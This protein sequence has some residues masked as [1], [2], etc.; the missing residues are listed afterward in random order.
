MDLGNALLGG[1][2][3]ALF[4][5]IMPRNF[6]QI[7]FTAKDVR[8]EVN[9][10]FTK[11]AIIQAAL[12]DAE[13]KQWTNIAVKM[14]IND[15]RDFAYDLE[16]MLDEH[17]TSILERILKGQ[18]KRNPISMTMQEVK[19]WWE[20]FNK[21]SS[22]RCMTQRLEELCERKTLL[23]LIENTSHGFQRPPSTSL[24]TELAICG[25]DEDKRKL[26]EMMSAETGKSNFRV[27]SI[28][29]MSGIGKTTLAKDVF[30]DITIQFDLKVWICVSNRFDVFRISKS[31]L[32][33]ISHSACDLNDLN[34][35]QMKL[36]SAVSGKRFLLVLD[37]VW[38]KHYDLWEIFRS[39]LLTGG[40]GSRIL[41]T[42][43]SMD[44]ALTMGDSSGLYNLKLLSDD[45]CWHVFQNH[46]FGGTKN[47]DFQVRDK[48]VQKCSGLPLAARTLG[49]LLRSKSRDDEWED[50]LNS[51]LWDLPEE[52]SILPVLKLNY[53]Y[54]P[55]YLKRCFA[56]CAILPKNYEFEEKEL[57]HL[58]IAEGL[59]LPLTNNR[60]LEEM[61]G[62]Y[63]RKL[64]SKSFF[65]PS[66]GDESKFVMHN[67]F[68]DL[69]QWVS[70]ETIF[71]REDELEV[72]KMYNTLQHVRHYSY[73]VLEYDGRNKFKVI[74]EVNHE[75][76][77]TFLPILTHNFD[78]YIS[79]EVI[80]DLLPKLKKLRVLSLRKY[81][82]TELPDSIGKLRYLRYLNLADTDIASLPESVMD[83]INLQILIL[84]NCFR[85]RKL[86]HTIE[87]LINLRHLDIGGLKATREMPMGIK[88]LKYLETLSN[89]IVGKNSGSCLADLKDLKFLRGELHISQ[90]E[91]RF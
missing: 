60:P 79:N 59:I 47:D 55:S 16:D 77:R 57:V 9:K 81:H 3:Q 5:R 23:G 32:E 54:L 66:S 71:R 37:D 17:N 83:L 43:T 82:I 20:N 75:Q 4:D 50:I 1:F 44:V 31:I 58:W 85:L 40:E 53:S 8:S 15:L 11:L 48:V 88:E 78:H 21:M 34:E 70:R 35:L 26:L 22:S 42:T 6:P 27:L 18:D 64:L 7:I 86:P 84:R 46:A 56:F 28:V 30:N 36:K 10:W 61:G 41:V 91:N 73:E 68:N 62:E 89:F 38:N 29:G 33:S 51:Q 14:W 24:P 19:F 63:F 12:D 13:E 49:G 69:T 72:K 76:L 90:L 25:R 74:D 65:Q 52:S 80:S 2:F 39:P 67:L 87:R 45:D